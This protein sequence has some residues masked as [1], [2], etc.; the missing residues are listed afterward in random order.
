LAA[1]ARLLDETATRVG[2]ASNAKDCTKA[3]HSSRKIIAI[4]EAGGTLCS[5]TSALTSR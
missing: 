1:A 4:F 5:H 3:F 2:N